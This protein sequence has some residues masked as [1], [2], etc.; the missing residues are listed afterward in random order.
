MKMKK[1]WCMIPA[2]ILGAAM[3]AACGQP[4]TQPAK[5]M[6]EEQNRLGEKLAGMTDQMISDA[7][8]TAE[9]V[10]HGA[11]DIIAHGGGEI[12]G[13]LHG[14][15]AGGL[16]HNFTGEMELEA[17]VVEALKEGDTL[18]V[19]QYSEPIEKIEKLE[20]GSYHILISW[21]G[22]AFETAIWE[23]YGSYDP[24]SGMLSYE[25]GAFSVHTWDEN[26]NETVSEEE[27][28]AGALLREGDKLRWQDSR[29]EETGLFARIS[30]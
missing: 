11:Q 2:L 29:N 6:A 10:E 28:T 5:L 22:G 13:A 9:E 18:T 7:M 30:A 4:Q 25:D 24:V 14:A 27:K 3:L 8:Q 23:I 17:A 15:E 12:A 1:S 21:G 20:D 16:L 19:G 26:G